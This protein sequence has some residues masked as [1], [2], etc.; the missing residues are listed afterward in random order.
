MTQQSLIK[1]HDE[2]EKALL[3]A[4]ENRKDIDIIVCLRVVLSILKDMLKKG[5]WE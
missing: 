3:R 2:V 1:L 5:E 4:E